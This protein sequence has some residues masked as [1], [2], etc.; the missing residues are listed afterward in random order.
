[1]IVSRR[2]SFHA[3]LC[4]VFLAG[5]V[6]T[7]CATGDPNINEAES[8]LEDGNYEAAL[9][10]VERALET[11][12]ENAQ[13]YLT[14]ADIYQDQAAE[15][16]DPEERVRLY[17]M[18][19]EAQQ[20]AIEIN[21]ELES[22]IQGQRQFAYIDLMQQGAQKFNEAQ[23]A[24][25]EA[26]FQETASFFTSARLL[27]PDSSGAYINEAY[28]R[29]NAGERE[30]VIP[31]L[32]QGIETSPDTVDANLYS[33]LGSLYVQNE[34]Y[35]DAITLLDE[36]TGFYADNRELQEL[37]LNA[38][39]ASGDVGEALSA[40]REQV[41]ANPENPI[42]R[43]N[44]GSLLLNDEQYEE[45]ATQLERATELNPENGDAFFNLGASYVNQAAN[46][47]DEISEIEE[48]LR[49]EER[50][51]TE[52]ERGRLETLSS[53]RQAL[54]EQSIP[55]FEQA[56]DL[57]EPSSPNYST[58]CRE[59]YR[60]YVLVERTEDAEELES[61]FD[62]VDETPPGMESSEEGDESGGQ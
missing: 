40:Y 56:Y 18:V 44:Y 51:A 7:G 61:C 11:N 30:E 50:E 49:E 52:E 47:D 24:G 39:T 16:S 48:R 59:L 22:E 6:L 57:L 46:L 29:L 25:E 42:F 8:A 23:E 62:D 27:E 55:P 54:I 53:E 14:R 4:A 20:Q 35:D 15:A 21:P 60:S 19:A 36:A 45:A 32:E 3:L 2:Y 28:A 26:L 41:E 13:A 31:V 58:V 5:A 37:R 17:E 9:E 34:R 33:I 12:P 1:M 10:S 43:Y 38:Y